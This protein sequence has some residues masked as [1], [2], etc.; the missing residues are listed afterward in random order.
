MSGVTEFLSDL[1]QEWAR[2]EEEKAKLELEN[3][4][5]QRHL[6][7]LELER[8]VAMNQITFAVGSFPADKLKQYEEDYLFATSLLF[9]RDAIR[10]AT[11]LYGF[12]KAEEFRRHNMWLGFPEER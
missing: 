4:V 10:R 11:E 8:S 5:R 7:F 9:H 12:L 2:L 3:R 1:I 6:A